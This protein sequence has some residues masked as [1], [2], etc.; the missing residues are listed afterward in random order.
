MSGLKTG[1]QYIDFAMPWDT[2]KPVAFTKWPKCGPDISELREKSL[3]RSTSDQSLID[4][5]TEAI[6]FE[7]K[8]KNTLKSMNID[9]IRKK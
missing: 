8:K 7:E 6:R 1:E 9:D 5:K 3:K 2:V 4:M